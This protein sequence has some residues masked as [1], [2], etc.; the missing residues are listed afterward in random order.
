M[1]ILAVL[2]AE[3]GRPDECKRLRTAFLESGLIEWAYSFPGYGGG[4]GYDLVGMGAWPR[5]LTPLP[6]TDQVKSL[7]TGPIISPIRQDQVPAAARVMANAFANAPRYTFLLPNDAQR[8]ARL[9]WV[10]AQPSALASLR[11]SRVRR[12]WWVR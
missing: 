12:P 4:V 5:P 3:A 7:M 9:P 2:R 1:L 6:G 11:R 8:Q 10:W